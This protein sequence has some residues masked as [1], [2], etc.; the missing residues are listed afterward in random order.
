M[1]CLFLRKTLITCLS[2]SLNTIFTD[3]TMTSSLRTPAV[4]MQ[5]KCLSTHFLDL[6]GWRTLKITKIV[7]QF[8]EIYEKQVASF[9]WIRCSFSQCFDT[10]VWVKER[11]S[12][13]FHWSHRFFSITSIRCRWQTR[14]MRC[15]TANMLQTKIDAV[16]DKLATELSWQRLQLSTF[17]SYSE[18]KIC[19]KS[20]ILTYPPAY[21]APVGWP[22][23]SFGEIFG[24]KK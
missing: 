18:L 14:A 1:Y 21:G 12:D 24:N 23:L 3:V 8:S 17:S 11:V 20:Q 16:C 13:L 10:V 9:F 4:S 6:L 19:R 2:S 7:A 15:I 5:T 22:R